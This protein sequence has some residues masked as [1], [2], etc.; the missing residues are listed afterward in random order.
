MNIFTLF[1]YPKDLALLIIVV[2]A[3]VSLLIVLRIT[4]DKEIEQWFEEII[5]LAPYNGYTAEEIS[6]F[7]IDHWEDYYLAGLT[8][9][10]AIKQK[11]SEL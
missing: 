7:E 2:F 8:P 1:V 5:R 10:E 9:E 3:I 11:L 4:F 6:E